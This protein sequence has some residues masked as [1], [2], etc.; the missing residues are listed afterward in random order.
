[1]THV[2]RHGDQISEMPNGL[3]QHLI[4]MSHP[5]IYDPGG[6]DSYAEVYGLRGI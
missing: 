3:C 2:G 6:C 1:M 4:T 5:Q